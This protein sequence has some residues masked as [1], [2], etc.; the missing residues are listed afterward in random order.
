MKRWFVIIVMLVG[1]QSFSQTAKSVK[2]PIQLSGVVV[3]GDSLNPVPATS[4][5]IVKTDSIDYSYFFSVLTDD[6]GFFLLMAKPGDVLEFKKTGYIDSR[7]TVPDTL[8][9]TPPSIIHLI[10]SKP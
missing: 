3:A 1:F 4:I 9:K 7:Y 5:K 10:E 2:K 6:K 8:T